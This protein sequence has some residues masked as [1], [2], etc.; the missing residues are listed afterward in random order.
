MLI[1]SLVYFHVAYAI[2]EEPIS[3]KN[4]YDVAV[5]SNLLYDALAVP[6]MGVEI[7]MPHAWSLAGNLDYAWW[8]K[9]SRH[10]SWRF[11]GVEVDLRRWLGERTSRTPYT[12]HHLG[13]YAQCYTYDFALGRHG[14]L[15]GV[16]KGFSLEHANYSFGLEYGYTL[17]LNA[18]LRL[19]MNVGLG[20]MGGT[21]Q[22]YETREPCDVWQDS[23]KRNWVGPTKAEVSLVW[24]LGKS[25]SRN[26][27]EGG[28]R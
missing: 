12:G 5:R 6:N 1:L 22:E 24:L 2:A 20:Y 23:K 4:T 19:D 21:Y 11:M 18:R 9:H 27:K 17:P 14:Y 28:A 16:S 15:G 7:F 8:T 10:R 26:Q 13:L 3:S 25:N